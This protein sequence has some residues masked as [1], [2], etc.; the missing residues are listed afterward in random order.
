ETDSEYA[1]SAVVEPD[2]TIKAEWLTEAF[3]RDFDLDPEE[4]SELGLL[5]VVAPE[6]LEE[7]RHGVDRLREGREFLAE[8]RLRTRAG[9]SVWT[10]FYARPV[11]ERPGGRLVRVHGA[12]RSIEE[13]KELEEKLAQ[14]IELVRRTDQERRGLLARLVATVACEP[15]T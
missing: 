1:W 4:P 14:T 13:R 15:A 7:A 6:D 3:A 8:L 12:V 10:L 9:E 11:V 5:S 2:G